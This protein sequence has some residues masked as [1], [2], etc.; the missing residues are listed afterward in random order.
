SDTNAADTAKMK[1]LGVSAGDSVFVLGFPL[2]LGAGLQRN[3]VIVRPG[4]IA[5]GIDSPA[6]NLLIDSH[7]SPGNSGGHVRINE[8]VV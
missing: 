7:V 3:Y 2:N 1:D 8:E 5:R 4:A 6:G